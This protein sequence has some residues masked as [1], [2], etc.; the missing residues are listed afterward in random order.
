MSYILQN[1][2]MAS[3]ENNQLNLI[4]SGDANK[5]LQSLQLPN[6][7]ATQCTLYMTPLHL[8]FAE[9]ETYRFYRSYSSV[10][11]MFVFVCGVLC[12]GGK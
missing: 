5:I 6:S 3:L 12:G 2:L 7:P 1:R 11:S 9:D 8:R 4:T 10:S